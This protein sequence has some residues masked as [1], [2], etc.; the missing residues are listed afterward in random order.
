MPKAFAEYKAEG[1]DHEKGWN[2]PE[3]LN[4]GREGGVHTAAV[5]AGPGSDRD[6]DEHGD[7]DGDKAYGKGD[8]R[9]QQKAAGEVAAVAV[10]SEPMGSAVG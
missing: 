6:S 10:G 3:N 1:H 8:A 5:V 9:A 4:K 7:S 2:A